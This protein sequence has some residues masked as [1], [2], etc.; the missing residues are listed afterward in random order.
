MVLLV[1]VYLC[2]G[3]DHSFFHSASGYFFHSGNPAVCRILRS[4]PDCGNQDA[5]VGDP[6]AG[7]PSLVCIICFISGI[8]LLCMGILGQYLAKTY[9]ET[10]KRPVYLIREKK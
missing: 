10:K 6:V 5:G 7:Y 2:A 9:L 8:Q 4:D 1:A 3:W